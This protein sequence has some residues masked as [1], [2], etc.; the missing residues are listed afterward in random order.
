MVLGCSRRQ[1]Q[2]TANYVPAAN[3]IYPTAKKEARWRQTSRDFV[4]SWNNGI[5]ADTDTFL[6]QFSPSIDWYDHAFFLHHRGRETLP[7]FRRNWLTNIRDFHCEIKSIDLIPSGWVVR[8][9]YHGTMVGP[10]PGR[11][12]S[13]KSFQNHVLIMLGIG[14][15]GKIGRV[16]EYYTATLDEL[17]GC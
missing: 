2:S 16:D 5:D 15:D 4:K 9:V 6:A 12:A 17:S 1:Y 8:C 14:E 3:V 11:R 7:E 13:G 10:P